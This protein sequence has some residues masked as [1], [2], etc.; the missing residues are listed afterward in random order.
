MTHFRAFEHGSPAFSVAPSKQNFRNGKK[1]SQKFIFQVKE[2]SSDEKTINF[3][4]KR[5]NGFQNMTQISCPVDDFNGFKNPIW[6]RTHV[7]LNIK[8]YK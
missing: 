4:A 3:S 8:S 5:D 7:I 1:I 2:E 6:L